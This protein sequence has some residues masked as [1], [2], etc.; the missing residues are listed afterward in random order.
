MGIVI[1]IILIIA[2]GFIK[3]S[4]GVRSV[5][6]KDEMDNFNRS[7]Q[8]DYEKLKPYIDPRSLAA[9]DYEYK[10][11]LEW[12]NIKSRIEAET[13][14]PYV[15]GTMVALGIVAQQGKVP[16]NCIE[17]PL[18]GFGGNISDCAISRM[19]MVWWDRELQAHGFPEPMVFVKEKDRETF[20]HSDL[21]SSYWRT[22]CYD[23]CTKV[24]DNPP[25]DR[26]W[27]IWVSA[28]G[29]LNGEGQGF[30]TGPKHNWSKEHPEDRYDIV[31]YDSLKEQTT[32]EK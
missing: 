11:T 27:Y 22:S 8:E 28:R 24:S 7:R 13:D 16:V 18:H 1:V 14:I 25:L 29:A 31:W 19:F 5:A 26:G 23:Y 2:F 17:L 30:S 3:T 4:E 20:Y 15:E 21:K 12:E 6:A 32:E 9:L 10:G